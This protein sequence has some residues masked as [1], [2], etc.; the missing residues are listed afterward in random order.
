VVEGLAL[1]GLTALAWLLAGILFLGS[2]LDPQRR[3]TTAALAWFLIGVSSLATLV[4][5]VIG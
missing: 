2:G 3:G 4:A 5:V 1:F